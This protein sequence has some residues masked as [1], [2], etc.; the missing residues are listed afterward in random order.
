MTISEKQYDGSQRRLSVIL[1]DPKNNEK[2]AGESAKIFNINPEA[3]FGEAKA[4]QFDVR[5]REMIA[6]APGPIKDICSRFSS[7]E[8]LTMALFAI[9]VLTGSILPNV[10]I[11]YHKK[12][13]YPA[14]MLLAIYPPASGKGCLS[15]I[16]RLTSKISAHLQE[17]NREKMR[18]Y[19][20]EYDLYKKG[21]KTGSGVLPPE[22]PLMPMMDMPGDVTSAKLI[23]QL[24]QNGAG[25]MLLINEGEA[26]ALGNSL[27]NS[28][29]GAQLS[30]VL[31]SSFEFERIAQ[32]RKTDNE[33][34]VAEN[35]KLAVIL[36]GTENQ[37]TKIF[38]SN[39]D[40]LYSRFLVLTGASSP[41]WENV[42]P[43]DSKGPQDD[44]FDQCATGYF[45]MWSFYKDKEIEIKFTDSQ[46][47]RINAFGEKNLGINHNFKGELT[48]SLAKRHAN[49]IVRVA[50]ALTILNESD[51]GQYSETVFCEDIDFGIALDMAKYSLKCSLEIYKKLP[52][53]EKS[54]E[55]EDRMVLLHLLPEF[56][57]TGEVEKLVPTLKFSVKTIER[58]IKDFVASGYL[59]KTGHGK[60]QKTPL[61][62][63][64]L[65]EMKNKN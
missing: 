48:G 30:N 4:E 24:S 19:K 31:R 54:S 33:L 28:Q 59:I 17:E 7:T 22:K 63:L 56:F 1:P 27:T 6:L 65:S 46:W 15:L 41:K 50:A 39:E 20:F 35:P 55:A 49:M 45:N 40:G 38:K 34:L 37:I 12:T 21:L 11:H 64:T 47:G 60:Y 53:K 18:H 58:R 52:A 44:F 5:L 36:S 57:R 16:R 14:L 3:D 61:A 8:E 9:T 32:A 43:D 29:Y 23:D 13:N 42:K 25:Q 62:Y 2:E 51:K 26:D 10:K